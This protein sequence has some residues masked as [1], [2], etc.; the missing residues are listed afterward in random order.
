MKKVIFLLFIFP[1]LFSCKNK[2]HCH[3]T[4]SQVGVQID[5]GTVLQWK[6]INGKPVLEAQVSCFKENDPTKP[7]DSLTH[8]K[9]I[10]H[11]VTNDG[12]LINLW[13][14]T[15]L[16]QK[17]HMRYNNYVYLCDDRIRVTLFN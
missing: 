17:T 6:E 14:E 8:I 9:V 7:I 1:L 12:A 10:I 11:G 4:L 3:L 16:R 5:S 15:E 2:S 13:K